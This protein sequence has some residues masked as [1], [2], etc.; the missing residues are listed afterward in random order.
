MV[1][2]IFV[3][4]ICLLLTLP[5]YCQ[6]YSEAEFQSVV[7]LLQ[8]KISSLELRLANSERRVATLEWNLSEFGKYESMAVL[9]G[10]IHERLIKLERVREKKKK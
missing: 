10:S 4:A 1:S 9:E 7:N 2:R 3:S 8:S 5:C 6:S